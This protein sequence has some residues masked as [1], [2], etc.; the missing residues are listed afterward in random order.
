M[1]VLKKINR[2]YKR[3]KL[4]IVHLQNTPNRQKLARNLKKVTVTMIR[5][6]ISNISVFKLNIVNGIIYI[7]VKLLIIF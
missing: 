1:Y 7:L 6:K 2:N 4:M 5:Q 3:T